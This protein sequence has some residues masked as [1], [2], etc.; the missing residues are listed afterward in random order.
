[1]TLN[2][3]GLQD[4]NIILVDY[5]RTFI[6][7]EMEVIPCF[8]GADDIYIGILEVLDRRGILT[9]YNYNILNDLYKKQQEK[10]GVDPIIDLTKDKYP[11]I[12]N[13][14]QQAGNKLYSINN[15]KTSC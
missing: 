8:D 9:L 14:S 4:I 1:M 15:G 13:P 7:L 5:L 10:E 12:D 11:Y 2:E 6:L 3:Q